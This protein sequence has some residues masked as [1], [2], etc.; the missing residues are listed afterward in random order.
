MAGCQ[1]HGAN[2]GNDNNNQECDNRDVILKGL[3]E[4]LHQIQE[5]LEHLEVAGRGPNC[6]E[7]GA[8][9]EGVHRHAHRCFQNNSSS[10]DEDGINHF[11]DPHDN[12]SDAEDICSQNSI[13][14]HR[15]NFHLRVD[16][17]EFEGRFD[18]DGF[19]GWINTT[20]HVFAY[21]GIP[22]EDKVLLA[23]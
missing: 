13:G 15:N 4:Q 22:D 14:N 5:R 17:S 21:K 10:E 7:G 12:S 8:A 3:G 9:H 18:P 6:Q 20:D 19:I 11:A 1:R 16:L 23:S 2:S